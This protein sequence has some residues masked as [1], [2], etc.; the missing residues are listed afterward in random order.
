MGWG[1]TAAAPADVAAAPEIT[2]SLIPTHRVI[3]HPPRHT[4]P[5]VSSPQKS[6]DPPP[7][8]SEPDIATSG[9]SPATIPDHAEAPWIPAVAGM[10]PWIW[11]RHASHFRSLGNH[12]HHRPTHSVIPATAGIQAASR[13]SSDSAPHS[14]PRGTNGAPNDTPMHPTSPASP[15]S[16]PRFR[17][18]V[19]IHLQ[20]PL[21]SP[22]STPPGSNR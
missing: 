19:S 14:R 11:H 2:P 16:Y 13:T 1:A 20:H 6:G 18:G 5:P 9:A 12:P 7:A 17:V 22:P 4:P 3:P 8:A 10:T 15:M 21:S